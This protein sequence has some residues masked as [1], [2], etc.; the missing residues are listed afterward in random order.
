M[1]QRAS[2]YAKIGL[3]SLVMLWAA[4]FCFVRKSDLLHY[5][6]ILKE[7]ETTNSL[8]TTAHQI[9]EKV[10]KEIWFTQEDRSR[11]QYRI[12]SNTS[13]LTLEPADKKIH[14]VENLQKVRCWMQDKLYY[15]A[16][17]KQQPMQQV[18]YWEADHGVYRFNSHEL[19]AQDVSLSLFR[20]P[21]H[22]LPRNYLPNNSF[23]QGLAKNVSFSIT[24]KTPQFQATQFQATVNK[25]AL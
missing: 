22:Q 12:Y 10:H 14:I 2:L 18:R 4:L 13:L 15:A 19:L 7:Q 21:E 16:A 8:P 5:E 25:P 9:R 23:L 1:F 20:L 24:G 6:R 11:L 17:T 3:T